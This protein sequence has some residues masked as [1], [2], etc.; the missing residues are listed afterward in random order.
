MKHRRYR[1]CIDGVSGGAGGPGVDQHQLRGP[2][3]PERHRVPAAGEGQR[4]HAPG[5]HQETVPRPPE[6]V[7]LTMS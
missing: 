4:V 3:R 6:D 5:G 1:I 7:L 2:V